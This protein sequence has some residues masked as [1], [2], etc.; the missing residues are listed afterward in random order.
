VASVAVALWLAGF[1]LRCFEFSRPTTEFSVA[2]NG[3]GLL[4][5][6]GETAFSPDEFCPKPNHCLGVLLGQFELHSGQI[7]NLSGSSR[8]LFPYPERPMGDK[9][10]IPLHFEVTIEE[11]LHQPWARRWNAQ[12]KFYPWGYFRGNGRTPAAALSLAWNRFEKEVSPGRR[13]W[14]AAM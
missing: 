11:R 6:F 5:G 12:F 14:I 13:W 8:K 2:F 9:R 7:K 1:I 10:K 4:A 3:N